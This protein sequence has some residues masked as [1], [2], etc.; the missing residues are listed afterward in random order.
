MNSTQILE[1]FSQD[2]IT[3]DFFFNLRCFLLEKI[4][5]YKLNLQWQSAFGGIKD[6]SIVN[7]RYAGYA[8]SLN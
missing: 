1:F 8:T 2:C 3:G 5:I 7:Y 6:L 4:T